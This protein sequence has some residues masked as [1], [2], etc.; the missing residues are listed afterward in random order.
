MRITA[1]AINQEWKAKWM[2][3]SKPLHLRW[4][5][6][7]S[8]FYLDVDF[9][10][11]VFLTKAVLFIF[12]NVTSPT[13]DRNSQY[14]A[15]SKSYSLKHIV[16]IFFFMLINNWMFRRGTTFLNATTALGKFNQSHVSF[17]QIWKT[18]WSIEIEKSLLPKLGWVF[19]FKAVL[20]QEKKII[21]VYLLYHNQRY[22]ALHL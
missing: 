1:S 15:L 19:W 17:I 6:L 20:V 11:R 12:L 8:W 13:V 21:I 10:D 22:L 14:M 2:S 4:N 7:D 5:R 3:K 9:S 18:H 16:A